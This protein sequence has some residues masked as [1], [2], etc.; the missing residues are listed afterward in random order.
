MDCKAFVSKT[1]FFALLGALLFMSAE[2]CG[3]RMVAEHFNAAFHMWANAEVVCKVQVLSLDQ[4][5]VVKADHMF[6]LRDTP[7]MVATAKVLSAI[8]GECPAVIDI[9]FHA[10][11]HSPYADLALGEICLVFLKKTKT[12]YK[13][14]PVYG[15]LEVQP[16]TI[17]YG[18]SDTPDLKLLA[19]FLATCDSGG[20]MAKLQAVEQI[21]YL[22][23]RMI[24]R[25]GRLPTRSS[26][27]ALEQALKIEAALFRAQKA[28][29]EKRGS[30]NGMLKALAII[31]SFQA[32][33]SPSVEGP[34]ELLRRNP[35][36]FG[37]KDSLKEFGTRG[38]STPSL[39][40]RLLKTMDSTTRRFLKN[41]KDGSTLQHPGSRRS[42]RGV[43]GFDYA[44]FYRQALD[45]EV[46]KKNEK[47]RI[48]IANVIWIRYE[49]ASVPEM[50]Q[51]LDDSNAQIRHAAVAALRKCIDNNLKN[52]PET[53]AENELE[54]IQRW[55]T[56]WESNKE[57]FG[58]GRRD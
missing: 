39:Q 38:Y 10:L 40:L 3:G 49:E 11:D 28:L 19:E 23:K 55:K 35:A 17:D 1:L 26:K 53:Y 47:M 18:P 27:E 14:S 46:V 20:G 45:C 9:E 12:R 37:P 16:K 6:I 36:E 52:L 22:G 41:L 4:D 44:A 43:P 34:L 32:G 54:F 29:G 30:K 21:G 8:R 31:S 58:A 24:H 57:R 42:L 7:R 2:E 33:V 50:I 56:W 51:L 48:A 13:F 5:G 15:K 25:I